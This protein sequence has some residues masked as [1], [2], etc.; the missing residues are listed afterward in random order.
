MVMVMMVVV[1]MVIPGS[2]RRTCK[3][4]QKQ[5]SA[6]IFFMAE[7]STISIACGRSRTPGIKKESTG[8]VRAPPNS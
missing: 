6:R 1:M 7:C 4:H 2:E 5:G 8:R 3:H